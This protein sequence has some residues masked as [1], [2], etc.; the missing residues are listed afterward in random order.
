MVTHTLRQAQRIA[1]YVI[2]MYLGEVI[3]Q[4]DA[5]DIFNNPKH[6]LTKKYLSG[7]IS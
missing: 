6:E 4:G 2:F 3:E 1:D 7:S 5:K